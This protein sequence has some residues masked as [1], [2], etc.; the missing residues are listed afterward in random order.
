MKKTSEI[1]GIVA[2]LMVVLGLAF[3]TFHVPGAALL[4][5]IGLGGVTMA[6]IVLLCIQKIIATRGWEMAKN[7]VKY[8]SYM[9]LVFGA[10]YIINNF[11]GGTFIF[12]YGCLVFA[13][14]YLPLKYRVHKIKNKEESALNKVLPL[15]MI[16]ALVFSIANRSIYNRMFESISYADIQVN[17]MSKAVDTSMSKTLKEFEQNK[18]SFPAQFS[19]N[20][21]KAMRIKKLSDSLVDFLTT[22]KNEVVYA[23]NPDESLKDYGLEEFSGRANSVKPNAYFMNGPDGE[24]TAKAFEI[25]VRI[26]ALND[27]IKRIVAADNPQDFLVPVLIGDYKNHETGGTYVWE[28]AMFETCMLINDLAYLDILILAVKQTETEIA[29]SLLSQSRADAMWI[30][31]KKYKEL[32]P[33][34]YTK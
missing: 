18:N 25:R 31:W 32:N 21:T 13:V 3:K 9:L 14:A 7:I 2:A 34:R 22:C 16:V 28:A 11:P 23:T 6:Y 5:L 20:Y 4:L 17:T 15:L 29:S 33:D 27:S 30:F 12:N 8:T 1:L 24:L 26:E 19:S 10:L